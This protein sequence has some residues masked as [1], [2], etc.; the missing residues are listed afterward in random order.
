MPQSIIQKETVQ[1]I[2]DS[3]TITVNMN[4]EYW[5]NWFR[6]YHLLLRMMGSAPLQYSS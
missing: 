4:N 2:C 3:F 6:N 1:P 5:S